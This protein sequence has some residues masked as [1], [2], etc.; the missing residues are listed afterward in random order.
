MSVA[1][2]PKRRFWSLPCASTAPDIAVC[3]SE[4]GESVVEIKKVLFINEGVDGCF[5]DKILSN[6]CFDPCPVPFPSGLPHAVAVKGEKRFPGVAEEDG[7]ED[8]VVMGPSGSPAD[9]VARKCLPKS[10]EPGDWLFFSRMGGYKS[11]TANVAFSVAGR[12][13]C[14]YVASS[15]ADPREDVV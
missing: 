14:F 5:K 8:F 1:L 11:C 4:G 10:L 2:A 9:V 13:S 15:P 12:T 3:G 6:I 7:E